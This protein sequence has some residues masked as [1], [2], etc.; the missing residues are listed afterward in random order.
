MTDENS[1][2]K[3]FYSFVKAQQESLLSLIAY[4]SGLQDELFDRDQAEKDAFNIMKKFKLFYTYELLIS[5]FYDKSQSVPTNLI[6]NILSQTTFDGRNQ[7]NK[8]K[9][10]DLQKEIKNIDLSDQ[11]RVDII[12]FSIIPS[13]F[14][15]FIGSKSS[16]DNFITFIKN[17]SDDNKK[18]VFARGL[19]LTPMLIKLTKSVFFHA[20][21]PYLYDESLFL[22][23][24]TNPQKI[25]SQIYDNFQKKI[26]LFPR[27]VVYFLRKQRKDLQTYYIKNSYLNEIIKCPEKFFVFPSWIRDTYEFSKQVIQIINDDGLKSKIV[28][29]IT[30]LK[31]KVKDLAFIST[32]GLI[33]K[34]IF[35]NLDLSINENHDINEISIY[36]QIYST[37]NNSEFPGSNPELFKT[38]YKPKN[39]VSECS[40]YMRKLL[41][42]APRFPN[43]YDPYPDDSELHIIRRFLLEECDPMN[44]SNSQYL[45][46][47]L[48]KYANNEK[49]QL[50]KIIRAA[51]EIN[52]H[53]K[54]IRLMISENKCSENRKSFRTYLEKMNRKLIE[55][56][57]QIYL[58]NVFFE[59][60]DENLILSSFEPLTNPKDFKNNFI[61]Y[62]NPVTTSDIP[63]KT[64]VM[65]LLYHRFA[66]NL[67]FDDFLNS[68][69]YLIEIDECLQKII[70]TN[71]SKHLA[72]DSNSL[73]K[74]DPEMDNEKFFLYQY[75]SPMKKLLR[76]MRINSDPLCKVEMIYTA[77][78]KIFSIYKNKYHYRDLSLQFRAPLSEMFKTYLS[79]MN[80]FS[81]SLFILDYF[82]F[83]YDIFDHNLSN[84]I[85]FVI[86]F[87][88]NISFKFLNVYFTQYSRVFIKEFYIIVDKQFENTYYENVK[89]LFKHL[90]IGKTI[91]KKDADEF[92]LDKA[93]GLPSLYKIVFHKITPQ[94]ASK[95]EI[96]NAV[97]FVRSNFSINKLKFKNRVF[98]IGKGISNSEVCY[99]NG[100]CDLAC[101]L[102]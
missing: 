51:V 7:D 91:D 47:K 79:P 30:D 73:I 94:Q 42:N 55:Y 39:L 35:S 71:D 13:F 59:N 25:R 65:E 29:L 37:H 26:N 49:F 64:K 19:F 12:T 80:Y 2:I 53:Q 101:L 61:K 58:R 36:S 68:N 34:H 98:I 92:F 82:L 85:P 75:S 33:R 27:F 96:E 16:L 69:P 48:N 5:L 52:K 11:K 22:K 74:E 90:K 83:M 100:L 95:M 72:L 23:I 86:Q 4:S 84:Q 50:E 45:F 40:Y 41:I 93:Y 18:T 31:G 3:A 88:Q 60:L 20:L 62:S 97:L 54:E 56:L 43:K 10:G 15:Y 89:E 24:Q 44:K 46:Q 8:I 28:S 66:K 57:L 70:L 9:L 6:Q 17:I 1:R 21:E 81:S 38:L 63:H 67:K 76:A 78:E 77:F 87:C 102:N 99:I 32:T 14:D